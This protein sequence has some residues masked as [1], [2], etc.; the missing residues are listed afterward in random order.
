[1]SSSGVITGGQLHL[2]V[3]TLKSHAKRIKTSD[4]CT[5]HM[6]R[7]QTVS[8]D[9]VGEVNRL[10]AGGQRNDGLIPCRGNTQTYSVAHLA[11]GSSGIGILSAGLKRPRPWSCEGVLL[12]SNLRICGRILSFPPFSLY[13]AQVLC[14]YYIKSTNMTLSNFFL[15]QYGII[16]KFSFVKSSQYSISLRRGPRLLFPYI[17][18]RFFLPLSKEGALHIWR[19]TLF[20][21][22]QYRADA[23]KVI[24]FGMLSLTLPT[25]QMLIF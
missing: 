13:H 17:E 22:R 1:M 25:A 7:C 24:V 2:N 10:L 23:R 21:V 18:F 16:C 6:T 19:N 4:H 3:H 14:V 9:N 12:V 15:P 8:Q 11:S 20:N 5:V